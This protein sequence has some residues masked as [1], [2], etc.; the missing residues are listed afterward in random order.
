MH[1]TVEG[2]HNVFWGV[3]ILT[4]VDVMVEELCTPT[5]N[6]ASR[7]AKVQPAMNNVMAYT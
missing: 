3:F 4:I 1:A 6:L 2:A 7:L 5:Q